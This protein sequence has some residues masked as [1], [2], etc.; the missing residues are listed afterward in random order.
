[1]GD[2]KLHAQAGQVEVEIRYDSDEFRLRVRDDGKGI[3]QAV[4][5]AQGIEGHQGLRGMPEGAALIRGNC[6][7][8]ARSVSNGR[9]A[10]QQFRAHCPDI[11]LMDLQM[12]Q[13]NDLDA[14]IAIRTEFPEAEKIV[15]TTYEGEPLRT[16]L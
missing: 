6:R 7:C 4:L 14:L 5:A 9:E 10:I 13:I 1:V 15:L 11:T 8:G 16:V 12:P 3:D 2:H